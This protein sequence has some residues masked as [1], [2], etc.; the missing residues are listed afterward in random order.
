MKP[1]INWSIMIMSNKIITNKNL[2]LKLKDEFEHIDHIKP[3]IMMS[4]RP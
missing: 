2:K 1:E 3:W 4:L